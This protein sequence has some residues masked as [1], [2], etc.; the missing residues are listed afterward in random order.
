MA[1]NWENE[2]MR[3]QLTNIWGDRVKEKIQNNIEKRPTKAK[4]ILKFGGSR[5]FR[6]NVRISVRKFKIEKNGTSEKIG[7][8][9]NFRSNVRVSG[10]TFRIQK[11]GT[12]EK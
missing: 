6:S 12:S 7:G 9:R 5:N 4:T 10:R 2:K 8:S 11:I 3:G 1:K